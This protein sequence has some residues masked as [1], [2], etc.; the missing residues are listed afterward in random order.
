[1]TEQKHY[2]NEAKVVVRVGKGT[3]IL[4]QTPDGVGFVHVPAPWDCW[5]ITPY[6][7]DGVAYYMPTS[8]ITRDE[9]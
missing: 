2:S 5:M 6:D 3:P 4:L 8:M 7:P 9:G 1:M